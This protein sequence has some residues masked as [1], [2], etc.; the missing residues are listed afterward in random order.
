[1]LLVTTYGRRIDFLHGS[2]PA[3]S[4]KRILWFPLIMRYST[5]VIYCRPQNKRKMIQV[6]TDFVIFM[7]NVLFLLVVIN[8]LEL[9]YKGDVFMYRGSHCIREANS[10]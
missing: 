6:S 3:V 5:S 4:P 7:H 8:T 9:I 2:E 1:M 10:S